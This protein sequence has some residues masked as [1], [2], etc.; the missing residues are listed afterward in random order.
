MTGS[1]LRKAVKAM[2]RKRLKGSVEEYEGEKCF[3]VYTFLTGL[4]SDLEDLV[5]YGYIENAR[6]VAI[7][8]L[9]CLQGEADTDYVFRGMPTLD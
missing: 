3:C 6:A 8:E 1:E 2:V 4:E 9:A 5:A 7:Y